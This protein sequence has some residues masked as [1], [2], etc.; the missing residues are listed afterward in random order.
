MDNSSDNG[1]TGATS[2][3]QFKEQTHNEKVHFIQ[4]DKEKVVLHDKLDALAKVYSRCILGE[5]I[6]SLNYFCRLS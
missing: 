3:Q 2:P 5:S 4:V 6:F 1:A